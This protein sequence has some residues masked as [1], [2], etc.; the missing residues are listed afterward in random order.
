MSLGE[1]GKCLPYIASFLPSFLAPPLPEHNFANRFSYTDCDD[2]A[3]PSHFKSLARQGREREREG[4]IILRLTD[5]SAACARGVFRCYVS[6]NFF[7]QFAHS[8]LRAH[9]KP[10]VEVDENSG[11]LMK[12]AGKQ[13]SPD[14]LEK[15]WHWGL[16]NIFFRGARRETT[17]LFAP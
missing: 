15:S 3:A 8:C 13:E 10:H 5:L 9:S 4:K 7:L 11:Y 6:F 14:P 12:G 17:L 2:R 16:Q 1:D